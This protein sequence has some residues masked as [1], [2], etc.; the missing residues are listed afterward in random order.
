VALTTPI[1]GVLIAAA[2]GHEA[3]TPDLLLSAILVVTGI[4]ITMGR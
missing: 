3:L 1:W 2:I 4:A